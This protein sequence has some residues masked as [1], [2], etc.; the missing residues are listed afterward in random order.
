MFT[1]A[2]FPNTLCYLR[3][4][5]TLIAGIIWYYL[6]I[7]KAYALMLP[8]FIA[9]ALTDWLDGYFARKWQVQSAY[10]AMIDQITDKLF[11][12]TF[13]IMLLDDELISSVSAILIICREIF[14]SGL[15]EYL[16]NEGKSVPV[17]KAGKF[18][19]ALQMSALSLVLFGF[20][21]AQHAT[22]FGEGWR[23]VAETLWQTGRYVLWAAAAA[24]L[25]SAWEYA[26]G[27]SR[28]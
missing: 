5:L 19:T 28:V 22:L 12:C 7:P 3:V 18:K 13:L 14:V 21:I 4:L 25:Y 15:R 9:A 11:V 16:A 10:G 8:L 26:R 23:M 20:V 24:A 27:L 1:K 2:T 17:S 6:P